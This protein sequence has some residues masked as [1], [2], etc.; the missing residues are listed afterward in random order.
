MDRKH[1]SIHSM[2]HHNPY[3]K[4]INSIEHCS[5]GCGQKAQ[6]Q[7]RSGILCC[8]KHYNSCAG[9]RK[10]FSNL[11]H[12][13]RTKKSLETRIRLGITKSSQIKAGKTRVK[14]GHYKKLAKIMHHHWKDHPWD[15]QNKWRTYKDTDIMYQSSYEYNFLKELEDQHGIDYIKKNVKRGPCFY[16]KDPDTK[17][18]R[19][20]ISDFQID[21]TIFE[22]KGNYT[23]NNHGKDKKLERLNKAK[24]DS[25]KQKRYSAILVLEGKKIKI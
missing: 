15:N 21:S 6:Y 19:L 5:Y 25:V 18:E 11:D 3:Y 22:I 23:W 2:T 9:K 14:N 1:F 10:N 7:F 17:K 24:L 20:Y 4:K 16:Y 8:S 12:T 13:S